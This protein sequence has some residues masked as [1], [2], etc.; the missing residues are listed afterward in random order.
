[1]MVKTII[2]G[3]FTILCY[4][5][6]NRFEVAATGTQVKTR[7]IRGSSNSNSDNNQIERRGLPGGYSRVSKVTEGTQVYAA[8]EFIVKNLSQ[9]DR[10]YSFLQN[11]AITTTT[12]T[13]TFSSF[14]I[15]RAYQQVVAGMNY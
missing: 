10:P 13:T 7:M 3:L 5:I 1:M 4:I 12:T 8:A 14:Q 6:T 11:G 9:A 2:S 15:V